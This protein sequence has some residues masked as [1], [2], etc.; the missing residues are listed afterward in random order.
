MHSENSNL[1][2]FVDINTENIIYFI[3]KAWQGNSYDMIF[4]YE[5]GGIR[6]AGGLE[7]NDYAVRKCKPVLTIASGVSYDALIARSPNIENSVNSITGQW[8][9]RKQE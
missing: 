8:A 1:K 9:A 3:V 7:L 5:K 2:I 4:Y 6:S